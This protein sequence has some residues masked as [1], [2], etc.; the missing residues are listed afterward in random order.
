MSD[1]GYVAGDIEIK[2]L[3][4]KTE[5]GCREYDLKVQAKKIDI[6]ESI[7]YPTIYA[8]IRIVDSIGLLNEFPIIGEEFVEIEFNTPG[9]DCTSKYTLFVNEIADKSMNE[10]NKGES[11]TLRCV[12]KEVIDNAGILYNKKF[13]KEAS[14]IIK[15]IFDNNFSGEKKIIYN[16]PTRGIEEVLISNMRPLKAIDMVRRRATSKRYISSSY[17]F[18]ENAKGFYFTTIEGLFERNRK[19]VGDKVFFFDKKP[20]IDST[21]VDIRNILAYQHVSLGNTVSKIQRGSFTNVVNRF[22]VMT[23]KYT[24]VP[25]TLNKGQDQFETAD[26]AD[27][28]G[29]NSA[30]FISKRNKKAAKTFVVPF[31]SDK[32]DTELA[33]K[34]A[35]LQ[36]FTELI[37]S[38]LVRIHVY[39]DSAC[40]A[41][42]VIECKFPEPTGLEKDR[43]INRLHSGKYLISSLRHMITLGDR[44]TH[45]MSFELI[46]GNYLES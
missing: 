36:S 34:I 35:I 20:N 9:T 42:D 8:E 29:L 15:D 7:L 10:T 3:L 39:G 13:K 22:D 19:A 11:Y 31:S 25:Y 46:K 21:A 17:V 38:D 30:T 18:F 14:D 26:G 45:G 40:M 37:S 5:D 33:Q 12:S 4:L 44:Y 23:G 27:S 16:E 1:S 32:N 24:A 28:P 43:K 6:Y 41:G 2:K